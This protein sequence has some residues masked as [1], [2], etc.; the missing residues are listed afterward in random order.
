[1][2][3]KRELKEYTREEVATHNKEDS[4]W[5]IVDGRVYDLTDFADLHPG[6]LTVLLEVAGQDATRM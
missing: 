4:L 1:M 3:P 6:G 5:I 2:A